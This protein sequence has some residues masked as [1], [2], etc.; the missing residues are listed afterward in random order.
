MRCRLSANAWWFGHHS[1]PDDLVVAAALYDFLMLIDRQESPDTPRRAPIRWCSSA[2][3]SRW[4]IPSRSTDQELSGWPGAGLTALVSP[5]GNPVAQ[6]SAC[7]RALVSVVRHDRVVT[8]S[9][10][11]RDREVDIPYSQCP[12]EVLLI[13]YGI[14]LRGFLSFPRHTF[15]SLVA[16]PVQRMHV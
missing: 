14:F 9:V 4:A 15:L 7:L 6:G 1:S 8:A 12:D 3:W 16:G 5:S 2:G 10:F 11:A 13:A